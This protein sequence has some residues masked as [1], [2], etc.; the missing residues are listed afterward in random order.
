MRTVLAVAVVAICTSGAPAQSEQTVVFVCEHGAAK[1][2][3]AAAHFNRLAA[4]RGLRLRAVS[5]GTAPDAAVPSYIIEGLRREGLQLPD[6]FVPSNVSEGEVATAI[7]IVTF[8][9]SLQT[10]ADSSRL[11]RWDGLPAFGAGYDAASRAI[12]AKVDAL[13]L[14]LSR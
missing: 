6:G 12:L 1:S 3:V 9:V 7:R 13:I 4:E 11:Q 14:E 2:A 8:D 5:R 10:K